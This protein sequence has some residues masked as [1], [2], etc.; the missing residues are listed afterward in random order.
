MQTSYC[1]E[2]GTS[3]YGANKCSSC[4][5]KSNLWLVILI[6]A[7]ATLIVG[8]LFGVMVASHQFQGYHSDRR[9]HNHAQGYCNYSSTVKFT[10]PSKYPNPNCHSGSCFAPTPNKVGSNLHTITIAKFGG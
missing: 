7:L 3:L 2:C 6:T 8:F 1:P 9:C 10:Y 4:G 5:W